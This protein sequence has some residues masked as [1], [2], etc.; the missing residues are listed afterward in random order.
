MD[1]KDTALTWMPVPARG[2]TF[3]FALRPSRSLDM[4]EYREMMDFCGEFF[5]TAGGMPISP[6][7]RWHISY[8]HNI[9]AFRE[10]SD[11]MVFVLAFTKQ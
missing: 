2:N 10:E 3:P 1:D 11:Q 7:A 5:S 9:F 8:F 6:G 4:M